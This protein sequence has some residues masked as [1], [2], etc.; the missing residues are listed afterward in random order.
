MLQVHQIITVSQIFETQHSGCI[1]KTV[2]AMLMTSLQTIPLLRHKIQLFV[3]N[4][5]W[6]PFR[7]KYA[8]PRKNFATLMNLDTNMS[9]QYRLLCRSILDTEVGVAPAYQTRI[10]DYMYIQGKTYNT[11]LLQC[12]STTTFTTPYIQNQGNV[13]SSSQQNGLDKQQS[14]QVMTE[15]GPKL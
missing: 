6:M 2:S 12:L 3:Q 11:D 5:Q 14:I 10:Q 8:R 13:I 15:S 7:N 1:E 9:Q 4:F